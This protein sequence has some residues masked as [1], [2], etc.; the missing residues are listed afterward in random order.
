MF[1]KKRQQAAIAEMNLQEID[2]AKK[3]QRSEQGSPG[4]GAYDKEIKPAIKE[5]Q[6]GSVFKSRSSR[7]LIISH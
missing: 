2:R 4:P 6:K 5:K 7:E 3:A 1:L